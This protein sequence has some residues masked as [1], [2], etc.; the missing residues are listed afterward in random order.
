MTN[1]TLPLAIRTGYIQ[2][3]RQNVRTLVNSFEHAS[4]YRTV[5]NGRDDRGRAV[6]SGVCFYRSIL[7]SGSGERVQT[8]KLLLLKKGD[9]G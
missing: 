8:R 3:G 6:A 9:M 1:F 5:W 2:C 7:Q 4:R